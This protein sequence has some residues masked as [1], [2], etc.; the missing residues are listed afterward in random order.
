MWSGRG[1]E[2]SSR[3]RESGAPFLKVGRTAEIFRVVLDRLPFDEQPVAAGLFDRA[4][5]FQAVA[6]FGALEYR[7]GVFHAGLEFGF[8]AGLDVDLGDFSDHVFRLPDDLRSCDYEAARP[9]GAVAA[10]GCAPWPRWSR[11]VGPE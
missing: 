1:R 10:G 5:Q 9:C 8:H 11:S 6:A 2:A 3:P 7:R 4:L